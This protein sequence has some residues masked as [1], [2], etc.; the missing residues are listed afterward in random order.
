VI[1]HDTSAI[2][3]LHVTFERSGD[4]QFSGD[5]ELDIDLSQLDIEDVNSVYVDIQGER[6]HDG[7][8]VFEAQDIEDASC[9]ML[10]TATLSEDGQSLSG[11]YQAVGLLTKEAVTGEF[12]LKKVRG[13]REDCEV[14]TVEPMHKT[15]LRQCW[16]GFVTI[17]VSPE[18]SQSIRAFPKRCTAGL[19]GFVGLTPL[20][21]PTTGNISI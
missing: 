21:C 10:V 16:S 9:R 6:L 7:R 8:Y 20:C 12:Y 11:T 15:T 13:L 3:A 17:S 19:I 1:E 2:I 18:S 4:A 14:I 5:G